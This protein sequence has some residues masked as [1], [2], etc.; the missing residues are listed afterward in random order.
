V[1]MK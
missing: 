1:N